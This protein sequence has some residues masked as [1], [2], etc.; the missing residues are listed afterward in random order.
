MRSVFFTGLLLALPAI[1]FADEPKT[2]NVQPLTLGTKWEY[3]TSSMGQKITSTLEVT[4]VAEAKDKAPAIATLSGKYSGQNIAEELSA[5]AKGVYKHAGRG[6]VYAP[7][8]TI[9]KYPVKAGTKWIESQK[10]GNDTVEI[11]FEQKEAEKVRVAA[12]EYVA[13]PV[14]MTVNSIGQKMTSVT[15]YADGVGVV[16]V[17]MEQG[18]LKITQELK[19]FTPGKK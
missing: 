11:T 9:F 15:W 7:A 2:L 4:A 1:G 14:E 12:G 18:S 8:L 3:E 10:I 13:Y 6:Q 17:E 5:D 16:K 19:K